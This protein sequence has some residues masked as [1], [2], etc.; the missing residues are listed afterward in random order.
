M[1]EVAITAITSREALRGLAGEWRALWDRCPEATPFQRPE[2]LLPFCAHLGP[3]RLTTLALRQGPR[4]VGL[5]PLFTWDDGPAR[6]LSLLGAGVSDYLDALFDPAHLEA[7]AIAL[8]SHLGALRLG[9]AEERWDRCDLEPLPASSPLLRMPTP[10]GCR[11]EQR[12]EAVCPTL[13][14]P[15]AVEDLARVVPRE[16]LRNARRARARAEASG[17][18]ALVTADAASRVAILEALIA[19]HGQ[20]WSGQ[21]EPGM[22]VSEEVRALHREA[23]AAFLAAGALRLHAVT[24]DGRIIAALYGLAGHGVAR[25]YLQGFDPAFERCSPGALVVAHALEEA[26]RDG[27]R[28]ADFL[29]GRERY[30]Y[31]WGAVDRPTYRLTITP[32]A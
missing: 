20:R 24:L 10:P 25:F 11:A 8:A 1:S 17:R 19:L 26:V 27:Y 23:S 9:R 3:A 7:C 5:A 6:V 4:L 30:K 18:L 16:T 14:L 22:L 15:D 21:G 29:R 12:T 2:W 32:E 28:E 13:A 31:L